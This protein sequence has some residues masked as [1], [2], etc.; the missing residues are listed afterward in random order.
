M[1]A[2]IIQKNVFDNKSL[3]NVQN[4][5]KNKRKLNISY[6]KNHEPETKVL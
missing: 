2:N 4:N 1:W 5:D 6:S 3:F